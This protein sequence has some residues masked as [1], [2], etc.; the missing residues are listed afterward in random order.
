MGYPS[1]ENTIQLDMRRMNRI[2]EINEKNMYAVIEPYINGATLQAEVM[3]HGLNTHIQGSGCSCS[4]LASV[5]GHGGSGPGNLFAGSHYENLLSMEW[6]MPNGDILRTGSLGAGLGWFCGEGPGPS[7]RGIARGSEG[8]RGGLG[9]FTKVAL[10]LIPWPGPNKLPVVGT[11]PAYR[12][13]L[14][15]NIR[16]YSLAFPTWQAY[17]DACYKVWD[18]GIGYLAHRQFNMFGRDL[19][20]GMIKILTDPTKTLGDL[21]Q[22]LKDPEIKKTTGKMKRDF[23]IVLA[24]MTPRDIEWQEQALNQILAETGGWR[25][26]EMEEPTIRNWMLLYFL[27]LGHKNLN[28]VFAGGYEGCYGLHGSPDF[29]IRHIEEAAAF[30]AEWEKKDTFMVDQGGDS[31][32][33]PIGGLG[34]GGAVGWECFTCFDPH[35]KKST[36]GTCEFF[37]ATTRIEKERGWGPG[38]ERG[39]AVARGSDGRATPKEERDRIHLAATQPAAFHY[40]WKVK[41]AIDPNNLGDEYYQTLDRLKK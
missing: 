16:M 8:V 40:Q 34:G 3:K 39:Q 4:P 26:V 18:A 2:L 41:Q 14:P 17:A 15:D 11:V 37:E 1:Y 23:Y 22:L 27:R 9:I 10:K 13:A 24:G 33:G 7:L 35:D 5:T 29:G 19:K 28:F 32:M 6:V 30:K 25:V 12:A 20:V 21:E 38:M 31:T 36:E